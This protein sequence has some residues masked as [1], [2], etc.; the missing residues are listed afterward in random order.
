MDCME[1][2]R[3]RRSVRAYTGAPVS[4]E[5]LAGLIDCGRLAATARNEQP[6]EF[7]AVTAP[8]VLCAIA[9]VTDFGGFIAR[10]A[11]CIVVLCRDTK[12]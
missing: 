7:V 1:A 4:K 12:Y 3:T 10:A 5:T 2:L 6:W 8:E 9:G 11:A